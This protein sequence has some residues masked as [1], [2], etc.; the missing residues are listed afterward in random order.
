[1]YGADLSA[2]LLSQAHG[3]PGGERLARRLVR[4]DAR[5]VPFADGA[6]DAAVLL[7][8]SFGYFGEEGDE[9]VLD[10]LARLVRPGGR[11]VLDLM[12][13]ARIRASLVPSSSR[14]V[15]GG[16]LEEHRSLAD[17]GRRVT[18]QVRFV[19]ADG[20]QRRWNEDV[21]MYEPEEIGP[22]ALDRGFA[23]VRVDGDF[24][25]T[26]FDDQAPR[27]LILLRRE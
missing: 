2:A 19:G 20:S 27:Q 5:S 4:A 3:L 26:T 17:G 7:F 13:P 12:N 18:K 24:D 11:A 21:R 15:E 10:E 25:G 23:I 9:Q 16:R 14:R 8:S 6:F 1:M 22:M